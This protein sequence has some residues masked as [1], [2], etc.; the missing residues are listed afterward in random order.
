MIVRGWGSGKKGSAARGSSET[1]GNTSPRRKWHLASKGMNGS[2]IDRTSSRVLVRSWLRALS[3]VTKT[4]YPPP[5]ENEFH[6]LCAQRAPFAGLT[7]P[8]RRARPFGRGASAD[9]W[10]VSAAKAD[11]FGS[12]PSNDDGR[13]RIATPPVGTH[14]C[15]APFYRIASL[16][17]RS[18]RSCSRSSSLPCRS[19]G[20]M[21]GR[22]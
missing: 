2:R 12:V 19:W 18:C 17:A 11:G 3:R 9:V 1:R 21:P 15:S 14:H 4:Y 20:S 7:P 6:G 13:G 22:P 10:R 8:A 5:R 16:T